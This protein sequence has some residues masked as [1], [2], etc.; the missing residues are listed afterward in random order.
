MYV[1]PHGPEEQTITMV[2][3][4]DY[5]AYWKV[6]AEET[7][8]AAACGGTRKPRVCQSAWVVTWTRRK[9]HF[10]PS[11]KC[12]QKE[13]FR[14]L[15]NYAWAGTPPLHHRIPPQQNSTHVK[16]TRHPWMG[17]TRLSG[18]CVTT[19]RTLTPWVRGC[20]GLSAKF[21]QARLSQVTVVRLFFSLFSRRGTSKYALVIEALARYISPRSGQFRWCCRLN[22]PHM[23]AATSISKVRLSR[24]ILS[25]CGTWRRTFTNRVARC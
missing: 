20:I 19:R 4:R 25:S 18:S 12:R 23:N 21:G 17:C 5:N 10:W 6:I 9:R 3:R 22:P 2:L 7:D 13:R 8:R 24:R 11:Q 16:L 15:L 1:K 14:E